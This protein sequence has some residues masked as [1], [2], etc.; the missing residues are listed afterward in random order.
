M[1]G[2]RPLNWGRRYLMCRPEHFRVDYAINPWM[3][4]DTAVD[5]DR[6]LAQWDTLVATLRAAG[7]PR[8]SRSTS[9]RQRRTWYTR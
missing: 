2:I 4:V 9:W 5:P 8:W 7:A 1:T 6:A 3:D